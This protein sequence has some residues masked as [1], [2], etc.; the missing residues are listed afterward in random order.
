MSEEKQERK[1]AP[2]NPNG[3][4]LAEARR[5][6]YFVTAAEGVQ[7]DDVLRPEYWT[8]EAAKLKPRNRIEIHAYDGTW[9]MEVMVLDV[10]RAFARVKPII[11]PVSLTTVDVAQTQA[12]FDR[13]Q[14]SY[15]VLLR[16]PKR[17]SI[18]HKE[19]RD[20]IKEDI[21]TRDA[22]MLWLKENAA[23]LTA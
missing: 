3:L 9:F 7:P 18:V 6:V 19:S 21:E 15:E 10:S 2:L 22:A 20:I 1:I 23:K 13:L 14:L 4:E 17:W 11:G 8:H 16:G 5:V 12:Y